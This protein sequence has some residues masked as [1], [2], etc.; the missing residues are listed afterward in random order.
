MKVALCLAGLFTILVEGSTVHH[1]TRNE[2]KNPFT[3]ALRKSS[4]KTHSGKIILNLFL[5]AT[6]F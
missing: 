5:K 6:T 3:S 4:L 1:K 2:L